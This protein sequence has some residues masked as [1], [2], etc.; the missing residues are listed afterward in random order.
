MR[1][2][3]KYQNAGSI[4]PVQEAYQQSDIDWD[5]IGPIVAKEKAN[6]RAP[7]IAPDTLSFID[8]WLAA[9]G[10]PELKRNVILGN[11]IIESGGSPS[12]PS[13]TG[14]LPTYFGLLQWERA[15]LKDRVGGYAG[16]LAQLAKIYEDINSSNA[17]TKGFEETGFTYHK[18]PYKI[19]LNPDS[20]NR[21]IPAYFHLKQTPQ[22]KATWGFV[23][24]YVR[25]RK[26]VYETI[27]RATAA[28][29]VQ[30]NRGKKK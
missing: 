29:A 17:W 25:P 30:Q 28:K 16:L 15:R 10:V 21:D 8:Q 1:I 13:K 24:G 27:L 9:Q 26:T 6:K 11:I 7:Y 5:A 3:K 20:M 2:I 4:D 23:G 14:P 12:K 18:E 19:F 22:N